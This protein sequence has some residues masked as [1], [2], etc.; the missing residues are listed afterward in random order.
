M[1]QNLFPDEI[2]DSAYIIDYDRLYREGYRGVI[3]DVDNT[4][5]PHGAP[6]DARA[7]ALFQHFHAIGM[8][9]VFLSNNTEPRVRLFAETVKEQY[10]FLAG[11]PSP[12]GYRRAMEMMHT[13]TENTLFVGDQIFT[14]IWGANRA[15]ID[16]ILVEPIHPKEEIQIILKRRLEWIVLKAYER[17]RRL[18]VEKDR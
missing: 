10:I 3:Y 8:Q 9:A 1:F 15:G 16:T 11:K 6:A 7:K 18:T 5:V 12:K 17:H 2:A 4:L 14:D 13:G